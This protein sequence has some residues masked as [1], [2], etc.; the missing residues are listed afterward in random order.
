MLERACADEGSAFYAS[1]L[2]HSPERIIQ[3]MKLVLAHDIQNRSLTE[4]TRNA[5]GTGASMLARFIDDREAQRLNSI[6][7]NFK[8]SDCAGLPPDEFR[9]QVKI[10]D[11][12]HNWTQ[13]AM[14]AGL[15]LRR[16]LSDFIETVEQFDTIDPLYWQR[17][18]TLAGVEYVVTKKRSF[19]DWFS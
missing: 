3:A 15:T 8:A 13:N 14:M 9:K 7:R 19:G 10:I 1:S 2:P 17:V 18:Y 16:G 11:E 6:K 5:I 4:E 12:V